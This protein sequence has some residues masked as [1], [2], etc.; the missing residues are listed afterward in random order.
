MVGERGGGGGVTV[1]IG[2]GTANLFDFEWRAGRY[3][4]QGKV[5]EGT[6]AVDL[7]T[8]IRTDNP[9]TLILVVVVVFFTPQ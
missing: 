3:E 7:W 2:A 1:R 4:T 9:W 8:R 5:G 6:R